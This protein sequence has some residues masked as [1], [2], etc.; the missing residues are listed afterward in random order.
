MAQTNI[1]QFRSTV[2]VE[3]LAKANRFEVEIQTPTIMGI[4]TQ[5]L[6]N[7]FCEETAFP[8]LMI[9]SAPIRINNLN[10]PRASTI[11]FGG[12]QLN[13]TFYSDQKFLIKEYF[14]TW[15]RKIIDP[16]T[17][18][19]AFYKE[20]LKTN[21]STTL[22]I[23]A[24]DTQDNVIQEFEIFEAYPRAI[25]PLP[26]SHNNPSI[27][28]IAVTFTYKKWETRK[29]LPVQ[30]PN[31]ERPEFSPFEPEYDATVNADINFGDY[32]KKIA[33]GGLGPEDMVRFDNLVDKDVNPNY[34]KGFTL[35]NRTPKDQE[36]LP[37]PTD[38]RRQRKIQSGLSGIPD[39]DYQKT[40]T[41]EDSKT[42]GQYIYTS[43]LIINIVKRI[44]NR[45]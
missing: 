26:V 19:I 15:M 17:R 24:L 1:Q 4:K 22:I 35:E 44:L 29:Q 39:Q 25:A 11:D 2:G 6:I 20:G 12:N 33:L 30:T 43:Q 36:L 42:H 34:Q 27:H 13:F 5:P 32:A 14:D 23:K 41:P 18:E 16:K 21:Y 9:N 10:I 8:G 45:R 7:L 31:P 40:T 3:N 38:P 37:L 28:R